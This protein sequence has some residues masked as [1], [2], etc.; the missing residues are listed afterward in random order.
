MSTVLYKALHCIFA[1]NFFVQ[2]PFQLQHEKQNMV[3]TRRG[4][5]L[6][7]VKPH[8]DAA[9]VLS[10]KGD[11]WEERGDN[12]FALADD[13]FE[14]SENDD[15]DYDSQTPTRHKNKMSSSQIEQVEK[16]LVSISKE[17]AVQF[18]GTVLPQE[19]FFS[20]MSFV[21]A[22]PN[23][24]R[25]R[26]VSRG[27]QAFI[28]R[29]VYDLVDTLDLLDHIGNP[30]ITIDTETLRFLTVVCPSVTK[31]Y[32]PTNLLQLGPK[33]KYRSPDFC[34]RLSGD[35]LR[36]WNLK[37]LHI[38][39]SNTWSRNVDASKLPPA[40]QIIMYGFNESHDSLKN[41]GTKTIVQK[42]WYNKTKDI[43][44][45][46]DST[47]F[48]INDPTEFLKFVQFYIGIVYL[49]V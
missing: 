46:E 22:F 41:T 29:K 6:D 7:N 47:T 48:L 33:R 4:T 11:F 24:F 20:V 23:L 37:E 26:G 32:I 18:F 27:W 39:A 31:L 8:I 36:K 12:T 3:R 25:M 5:T 28:E 49:F 30:N 40:E 2:P 45:F 42:Y 13:Y 21:P 44:K 16:K 34:T 17:Q 9:T 14:N 10:D 15:D 1:S 43:A 35:I 19:I 38:F